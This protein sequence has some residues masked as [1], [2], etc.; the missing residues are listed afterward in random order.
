MKLRSCK[1]LD[2]WKKGIEI[3]DFIYEVTNRFPKAEIY[4]LSSQMQR[5]AV[6]I[7]SNVAEGFARQHKKEFV[8]FCYIALGSCA[9]LETQLIVAHN[10]RYV[11]DEDTGRLE[12]YL[13]HESRMLMNLIKSLNQKS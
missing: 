9:E 11:P 8:Q 5:S 12:E 3:V 1:D 2:V 13:D 4:G 7:P 6:S 10:R